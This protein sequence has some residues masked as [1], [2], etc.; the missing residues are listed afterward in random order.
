[1]GMIGSSSRQVSVAFILVY[2]CLQTRVID[3]LCVFNSAFCNVNFLT[4]IIEKIAKLE[5]LVVK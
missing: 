3:N 4:L 5:Y 1:M 2:I